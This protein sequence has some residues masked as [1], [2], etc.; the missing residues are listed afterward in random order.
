MSEARRGTSAPKPA[1]RAP[2]KLRRKLRALWHWLCTP[3][4]WLAGWVRTPDQPPAQSAPEDVDQEAV[5]DLQAA[6][7]GQEAVGSRVGVRTLVAQ[8]RDVSVEAVMDRTGLKRR[9]AYELLRQE[10]AALNGGGP[11]RTGREAGS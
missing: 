11:Q 2:S 5:V 7:G 9:R 6:A 8:D 4:R 1:Q 3:L 10:R